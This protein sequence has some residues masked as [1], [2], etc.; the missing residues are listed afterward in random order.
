MEVRVD[1]GSGKATSPFPRE[2]SRAGSVTSKVLQVYRVASP[3]LIQ[4]QESAPGATE[5][6]EGT[7]PSHCQILAPSLLEV[8]LGPGVIY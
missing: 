1:A 6:S 5:P 4:E 3:S 7:C 8:K 2:S